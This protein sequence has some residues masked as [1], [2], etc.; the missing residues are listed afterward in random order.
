MSRGGGTERMTQI[1]S[2]LLSSLP[3]FSVYVTSLR[4]CS[5]PYYKLNDNIKFQTLNL[6][7]IPILS[8]IWQLYKIQKRNSID[9]II[10]V[11]TFLSIYTIPLKIFSRKLKVISWEMFN[12]ANDMGITW[13]HQLRQF[14][15]RWGDYYICQTYK[16]LLDFKSTFDI[17]KPITY[18]YNPCEYTTCASNYDISSKR[19]VTA[20]NFFKTKGYDLATEV[21]KLVLPKHQDWQWYFYG[22]GVELENVKSIIKKYNLEKQVV[23]AGRTNDISEIYRNASIYVMTSRLEGFGLVL[24]EAKSYNLPT[25]AFDCPSGPREIIENNIS[26]FLIPA[27]K[28]QE[29]ADKLDFLISNNSIRLEFSKNATKNLHKFS[30]S[31]FLSTWTDIINELT[32]K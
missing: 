26:G 2:S 21:A 3:E 27:F 15:L 19:I 1:L 22:D 14:A 18:I 7:K 6:S 10:N 16:D 25:I 32:N 11:D 24:V 20:G 28:I 8:S 5:K 12:L 9:I 23:F 4:P 17:K 31:T 13:S 29:M 30:I